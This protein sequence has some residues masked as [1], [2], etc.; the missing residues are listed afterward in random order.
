MKL[1]GVFRPIGEGG[2]KEKRT[3]KERL[4]DV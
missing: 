3:L 4:S 1:K 2:L